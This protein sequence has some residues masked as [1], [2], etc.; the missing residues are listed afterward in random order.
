MGVLLKYKADG[1]IDRYK[2]RLVVKGFT[3]TYDV[4]YLETFSL[5]AK[6][7]TVRVLLSLAANLD[8]PLLQLDVKNA[9]LHGDLEEEIYMDILPR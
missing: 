2:A 3:H 5:V 6:L 9:F 4:D 1:S 8:W 7:N